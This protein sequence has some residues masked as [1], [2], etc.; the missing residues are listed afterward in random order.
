MFN[1]DLSL[2]LQYMGGDLNS[3]LLTKARKCLSIPKNISS[4]IELYNTCVD[5]VRFIDWLRTDAE[6]NAELKDHLKELT[7][8]NGYDKYILDLESLLKMDIP[9][10]IYVEPD[11]YDSYE[12]NSFSFDDLRRD[13]EST[14]NTNPFF[15]ILKNQIYPLNGYLIKSS[16]HSKK[17]SQPTTNYADLE[18]IILASVDSLAEE[19]VNDDY[20]CAIQYVIEHDK[21]K[22]PFLLSGGLSLKIRLNMEESGCGYNQFERILN[23]GSFFYN[24]GFEKFYSQLGS[25]IRGL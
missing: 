3:A 7:F 5:N 14:L 17:G 6:I 9:F 2:F 1:S 12:C 23:I 16:I 25:I 20:E 10:S 21:L 11:G 4:D 15:N 22:E 8:E 18:E 19:D 24:K 13:V